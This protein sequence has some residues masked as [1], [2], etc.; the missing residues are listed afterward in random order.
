MLI[1]EARRNLEQLAVGRG[2]DLAGMNRTAA[3]DLVLDWYRNE[4]A[5]DADPL[6]DDGD[7]LLFQYGTWPFS[8]E[9]MFHYDLTRQFALKEHGEQ[10]LWQLSLALL[11]TPTP[12]TSALRGNSDWCFDPAE[13]GLL[14]T[15]I[16]SSPATLHVSG[17]QPQAVTLDFG[18]V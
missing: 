10:T 13:A 12:E 3:V 14:R 11:Y 1:T 9:P 7:G 6:P 15:T 16:E 8:G 2:L 4:R 17:R 5:A 18:L